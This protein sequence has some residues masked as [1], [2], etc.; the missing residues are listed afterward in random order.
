MKTQV[1][2]IAALH[3]ALGFLSLLAAIIL[4]VIL[5]IAGGI[6]FANDQ[7]PVAGFLGIV[8][9]VAGIFLALLSLPG[10][11]GGWALFTGRS[12]GRPVIIVLGILELLNF[13]LGTALGIYTLCI[14]L[15]DPQSQ[16][17]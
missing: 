9:V 1:Q 17:A 10:I 14:L 15:R 11:I 16:A 6:A 13:P 3:M 4:F 7:R 8:G 12:W 2:V 5:G